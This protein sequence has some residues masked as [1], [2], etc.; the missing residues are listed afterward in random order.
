MQPKYCRSGSVAEVIVKFSVT[1]FGFEVAGGSLGFLIG[2]TE[3]LVV[4]WTGGKLVSGTLAWVSGG[5]VIGTGIITGVSSTA[6]A[7]A[8]W[9]MVVST[10]ARGSGRSDRICSAAVNAV[11]LNNA[12]TL[13]LSTLW[14]SGVPI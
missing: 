6:A 12:P 5:A 3:V 10:W 8:I 14:S 4:V 7:E 2:S 1:K 9:P 11:I 13:T